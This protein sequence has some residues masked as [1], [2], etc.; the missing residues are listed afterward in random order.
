[1]C[2]LHCALP[3]PLAARTRQAWQVAHL[4]HC[5]QPGSHSRSS[6]PHR[7]LVEPM[8]H[9]MTLPVLRGRTHAA[10]LS[11]RAGGAAGEE[12]AAHG[13][14]AVL[15]VARAGE[16]QQVRPPLLPG[17]A[18]CPAAILLPCFVQLPCSRQFWVALRPFAASTC[19]C[20][21]PL[22]ERPW[23]DPLRLGCAL[24]GA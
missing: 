23:H 14:G 18:A 13:A 16:L 20:W 5:Q 12:V 22:G 21:Q 17:A 19:P 4:P 10:T 11:R 7:V 1:M 8:A 6:A 2:T 24:A 9:L 3:L 15:R